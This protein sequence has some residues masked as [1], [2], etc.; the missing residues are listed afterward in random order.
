[1]Q[2]EM[3]KRYWKNLPEAQLIDPLAAAAARTEPDHDRSPAHRDPPARARAPQPQPT[4]GHP[5]TPGG[6]APARLP[7]LRDALERCRECP[8]GEHAT[9]A[10]P[11]EGP[12]QARLMFVGEQPGDQEDLQ[13]RPFVGPAGQLFARALDGARRRAQATST[14]P[15]PSSTSSSSCAASAA[16]TRRRRSRK[17]PPAC[18]GSRARSAWSTRRRSSPS[19]RPPRA[20]SWAAPSPSRASAASG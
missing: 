11:G 4:P 3:P 6:D 19:A 14:S 9:Q 10:V 7:A 12:A 5:V 18:T 15:T 8:I 16:S 20:S 2:K 1:M 13:G 17:P